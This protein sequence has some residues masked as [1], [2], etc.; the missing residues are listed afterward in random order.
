LFSILI[1]PFLAPLF[2]DV[3]F[4]AG[5]VQADLIEPRI[6]RLVRRDGG[7]DGV[8]CEESGPASAGAATPASAAAIALRRVSLLD[9][10]AALDM[11]KLH[12]RG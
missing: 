3:L 12:V 4:Q 6:G 5:D 7:K 1:E 8:G 10:E 9:G 11:G 2:R